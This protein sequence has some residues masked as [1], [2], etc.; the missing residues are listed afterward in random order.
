ME[1]QHRA[2]ILAQ[3]D[4][5]HL[6]D[7]SLRNA[8]LGELG[9][10]EIDTADL[11]EHLRG[12][13]TADGKPGV[14]IGPGHGIADGLAR[15][16]AAPTPGRAQL[17]DETA[18]P[19]KRIDQQNL[20]RRQAHRRFATCLAITAV[21]VGSDCHILALQ[22]V[23]GP[24][25]FESRSR[26]GGEIGDAQAPGKLRLVLCIVP[27]IDR[28]RPAVDRCKL[29]ALVQQLAI[30]K[31]AAKMDVRFHGHGLHLLPLIFGIV[32]RNRHDRALNHPPPVDA[33]VEAAA[34]G[35]LVGRHIGQSNGT[36]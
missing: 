7:G 27:E 3:D 29:G 32:E 34:M 2:K 9:G 30:D 5:T 20:I 16:R 11:G 25:A 6:G 23:G 35:R 19:G 1:T 10:P 28:D 36:P 31:A 13:P 18:H 33:D 24:S 22:P 26:Q 15:G 21:A 4:A 17:A 14:A 8:A 12:M